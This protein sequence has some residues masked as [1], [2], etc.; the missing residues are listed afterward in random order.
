MYK[1]SV[2]NAKKIYDFFA[3]TPGFRQNLAEFPAKPADNRLLNFQKKTV[4]LSANS[5]DNSV[6]STE[7]YILKKIY[8]P[9]ARQLYFN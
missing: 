6:N 4:E 9:S 2:G 1:L 8:V 3:S 5:T 7:F